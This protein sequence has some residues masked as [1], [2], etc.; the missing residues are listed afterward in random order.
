[1]DQ[2]FA[3]SYGTTYGT[4]ARTANNVLAATSRA[5]LQSTA[6]R[7]GLAQTQNAVSAPRG[8]TFSQVYNEVPAIPQYRSMARFPGPATAP[9]KF[10]HYPRGTRETYARGRKTYAP[11]RNIVPIPLA[12]PTYQFQAPSVVQQESMDNYGKESLSR[13]KRSGEQLRYHQPGYMGFVENI[14]FKHSRPFG[15]TTR[16]CIMTKYL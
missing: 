6:A 1:M 12:E 2:Q 15:P 10:H 13:R 11:A 7:S 4:A 5:P 14:Q 16:E 9:D 3:T 8:M